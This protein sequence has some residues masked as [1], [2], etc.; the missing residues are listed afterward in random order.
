MIDL[1]TGEPFVGAAVH[2]FGRDASGA[3]DNWSSGGLAASLNADTGTL[4]EAV[5]SPKGGT[6]A[7]LTRHPDTGAQ[8]T[9][10]VVPSWGEIWG[11]IL[12]LAREYHGLWQ[13]VGW[14][15]IVTDDDGGF[16]VIEGN[17]FSDVGLLQT[18]EPLLADD[19]V[20]RFFEHHGVV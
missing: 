17:A 10:T 2:R 9:G 18:H 7:R 20:R 12:N 6:P 14:D 5:A 8:V 1:D 3:V 16:V 15:V 19:C 4:G 11:R 13:Y